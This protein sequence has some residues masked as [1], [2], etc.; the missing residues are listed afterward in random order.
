MCLGWFAGAVVPVGLLAEAHCRIR[1]FDS[2][3]FDYCGVA[4]L[5]QLPLLLQQLH[6]NGDGDDGARKSWSNSCQSGSTKV[7]RKLA[8]RSS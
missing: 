7:A 1:V 3:P 8:A 4:G 2:L 5:L 6:A